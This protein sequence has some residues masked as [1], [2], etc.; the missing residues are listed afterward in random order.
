MRVAPKGPPKLTTTRG[1]RSTGDT[2]LHLTALWRLLHLD[3]RFLNQTFKQR[4]KGGTANFGTLSTEC[5]TRKNAARNAGC[6]RGFKL[7]QGKPFPS[8]STTRGP[9]PAHPWRAPSSCQ[10]L[11]W[12]LAR[13]PPPT[14]LHR[15]FPHSSMQV[16]Q[17]HRALCTC[18]YL[19]TG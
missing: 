15:H 12:P 10:P 16:E 9:P 8:G 18:C 7:L 1:T 17:A 3:L 4:Q 19:F 14:H 2:L 5:Q 13:S 11:G 6:R